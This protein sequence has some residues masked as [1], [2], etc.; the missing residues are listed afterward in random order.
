VARQSGF[1]QLATTG[2]L[3]AQGGSFTG[4]ALV[5][6]K[7]PDRSQG[8]NEDMAR[9]TALIAILGALHFGGMAIISNEAHSVVHGVRSVR[10]DGDVIS[11]TF[12]AATTALNGA[13]SGSPQVNAAG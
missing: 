6:G 9:I 10:A 4:V 2:E 11:A 1:A 3:T 8:A 7:E 13:T 5:A 12:N